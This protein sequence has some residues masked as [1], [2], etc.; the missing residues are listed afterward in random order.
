MKDPNLEHKT[1]QISHLKYKLV[2]TLLNLKYQ[3][4]KLN[5]L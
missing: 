3:F 5:N 2:T 4:K 1:S